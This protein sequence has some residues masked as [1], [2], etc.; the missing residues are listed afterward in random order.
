MAAFLAVTAHWIASDKATG[1]LSLKAALI[2]FHRLKN[3]HTG[4][5]I[6]RAIIYL[7]DRA[8]VTDKVCIL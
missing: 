5:N 1:S 8:G 3:R 7:L 4:R 6:A 2:G